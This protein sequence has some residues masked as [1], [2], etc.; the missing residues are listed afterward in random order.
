M[1]LLDVSADGEHP[2]FVANDKLLPE[3]SEGQRQLYE[4]ARV[5]GLRFV[6]VLPGGAPSSGSCTAG[7]A[8]PNEPRSPDREDLKRRGADLLVG[9]RL[10]GKA[11]STCGSAAS[12]TVAVSEAEKKN[13]GP[14]KSWFWGAAADGSTAIFSTEAEPGSSDLYEFDVDAK[15][16]SRSPKASVG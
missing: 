15:R 7:S 10:P 1:E 12:Q 5:A 8:T 2:I 16:P 6:C 3:G 9:A 4:S 14:S 13:R 11:R